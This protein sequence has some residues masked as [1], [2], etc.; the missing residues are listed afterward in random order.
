[1]V[2]VNLVHILTACLFIG[3]AIG[4]SIYSARNVKTATGFSLQGRQS[5]TIRVAGGIVAIIIGGGATIGTAQMAYQFGLVAWSFT[6]G[7]GIGL[8]VLGLFYASKL[9]RTGLETVPEF[10]GLHYGKHAAPVI[11]FFGCCSILSA[12][13]AGLIAG[14]A[15][16]SGMFS[17][18]PGLAALI[19][20]VPTLLTVFFSGQTGSSAV[21]LIKMAIVWLSLIVCSILAIRGLFQIDDFATAFPF[22]PWF[23]LFSIGVN[24]GV[25]N[26]ISAVIGICCAQSYIQ[27][28]FS[29]KD[30]KVSARGTVLAGLMVIPVGLPIVA[31]GMFMHYHHPDIV[32][33]MALP[34]FFFTYLPDWFGG[35]AIAGVLLAIIG[36]TAGMSLNV[37]TMVTR[38]FVANVFKVDNDRTLLRSSRITIV[39]FVALEMFVA[40]NYHDSTVLYWNFF[41]LLLRSGGVFI[42]LT[43]ALVKPGWLSP[44]WSLAS[45]LISTLAVIIGK[46]VFDVQFH[47]L[48]LALSISGA[49]VIIGI[50][51]SGKKYHEEWLARMGKLA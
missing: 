5:S 18:S 24:Q 31:I 2:E 4:Y 51:V 8:A 44:A 10:I 49:I 27:A 9:R 50:A 11:S 46:L 35:L 38:D 40:F 7:M 19:L 43:L 32:P 22:E 48:A 45:M 37:S 21:G 15:I 14:I 29:A 23:D 25:G 26:I 39:L 47:P 12:N 6:L 34:A 3:A 42:P 13:V 1:M 30:E 20:A 36:S 28:I 16:L 33:V 41:G 17:I